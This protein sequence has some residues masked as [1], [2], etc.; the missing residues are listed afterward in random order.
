[1]AGNGWQQTTAAFLIGVG[2][3]AGLGVLFAPKSGEEIRDV[4]AGSV[5][6]GV[7]AALAQAN[8]LGRRAQ[9]T[10]EDAKEQVKEAAAAGS[11]A[12]SRAK[13]ASS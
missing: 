4:I 10:L 2:V 11:Q 7:D 5:K 1:M 8:T 6:D 3:G 9:K 12:Y 13:T